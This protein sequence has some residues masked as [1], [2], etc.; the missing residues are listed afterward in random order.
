MSTPI[1]FNDLQIGDSARITGYG[2]CDV[3]YRHKLLAMG[4]TRGTE[5]LVIRP[6]PL[7]DP[8]QIQVRDFSL[9]L[10]RQEAQGLSLERVE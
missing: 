6:A 7:G 5:F 3:H 10:R 4:L 1:H 8:V 2:G 9:C